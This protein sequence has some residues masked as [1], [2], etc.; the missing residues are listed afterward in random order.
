MRSKKLKLGKGV[1]NQGQLRSKVQYTKELEAYKR[2]TGQGRQNL[3]FHS[4]F[5]NQNELIGM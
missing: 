5:N 2:G 4:S 1:I 3:I